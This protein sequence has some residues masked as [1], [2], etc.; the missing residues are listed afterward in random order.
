MIK[1]KGILNTFNF[2]NLLIKDY[3][4]WYLL[5]RNSQITLGSLVLIEKHFHTKLSDISDESFEEFGEIVREIELVI[6]ELFGYEK[7]NYLMLM[8][9][10]NE[11]HYHIIPRYSSTR[12]FDSLIFN[13]F[14]WPGLP[15]LKNCNDIEMDT[16]LK[17]KDLIK[18]RINN[19]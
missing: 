18:N 11:V 5:L 9:K 13:D 2:E 14:G 15:D 8:M 6:E 12:I 17:I 19:L 10:D 7:I 1:M 3:Q 16:K 4:N